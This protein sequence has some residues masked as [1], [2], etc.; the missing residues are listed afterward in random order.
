[1]ATPVFK[2]QHPDLP[3]EDL[4][5]I[6]N[7][8]FEL[9]ETTPMDLAS[10]IWY[11]FETNRTLEGFIFGWK[12]LCT[13][14]TTL[15]GINFATHFEESE[16]QQLN[17]DALFNNAIEIAVHNS[18]LSK[19]IHEMINQ[20]TSEQELFNFV[21]KA[22]DLWV[23]DVCDYLSRH[24]LMNYL[25]DNYQDKFDELNSYQK[26]KDV[27]IELVQISSLGLVFAD[28]SLKNDIELLSMAVQ[29]D[30]R[31]WFF[32]PQDLHET[33]KNNLNLLNS[34]VIS[35]ESTNDYIDDDLPF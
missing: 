17:Q 11:H 28:S 31:A 15:D 10:F 21:N 19:Q 25:W 22:K 35:D 33:V 27:L 16:K 9:P 23:L 2:F 4:Y 14:Q 34:S 6:Q 1:M 18:K 20:N 8:F 29:S 3:G 7:T 12:N 13:N 5:F 24:E 30:Y 26:D 32:V